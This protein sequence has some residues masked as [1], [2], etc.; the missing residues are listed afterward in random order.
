MAVIAARTDNSNFSANQM[1]I[2]TIQRTNKA[3]TNI[4]EA[5]RNTEN[6]RARALLLKALEITAK[7]SD[8]NLLGIPIADGIT[9]KMPKA[10]A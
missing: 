6:P 2:S 5:L 8:S 4:F 1:F 7:E 10:R 3:A 9:R